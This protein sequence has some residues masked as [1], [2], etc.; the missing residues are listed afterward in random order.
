MPNHMTNLLQAPRAVIA[1]L[2]GDDGAVDFNEVL[3]EPADL[4]DRWYQWRIANW[5]T[6]W[7]GYQTDRGEGQIRFTTAW[8][9]PYPVVRALSAKHP[10]SVFFLAHTNEFAEDTAMVRAE[11]GRLDIITLGGDPVAEAVA[12]RILD[13]PG[14]LAEQ[15]EDSAHELAESGDLDEARK[16]RQQAAAITADYNGDPASWMT[17]I[18]SQDYE[19]LAAITAG[20]S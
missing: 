11:A 16:L 12:L 4:G 9:S 20:V 14:T 13:V 3:P 2:I 7:N 17:M 15:L 18:L 1:D 5:G 6:K 19:R 8:S 10:A